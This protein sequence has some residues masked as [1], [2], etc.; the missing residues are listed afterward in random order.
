MAAS[1]CC[2]SCSVAVSGSLGI[3]WSVY[4]NYDECQQLSIHFT[5]VLRE[6]FRKELC[7]LEGLVS[8]STDGI[9]VK[10]YKYFCTYRNG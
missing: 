10:L 4:F 5:L 9:C 1:G 7:P 2:F 6:S 8:V 3:C